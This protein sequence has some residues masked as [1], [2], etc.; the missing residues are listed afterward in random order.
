MG[1]CFVGKTKIPFHETEGE[2]MMSARKTD[3]T[4]AS[5]LMMRITQGLPPNVSATAVFDSSD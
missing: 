4:V 5:L 1:I 3:M 2:V